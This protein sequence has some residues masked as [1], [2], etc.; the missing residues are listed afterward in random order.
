MAPPPKDWLVYVIDDHGY[1]RTM[2]RALLGQM[3]IKNVEEYEECRKAFYRLQQ[4]GVPV[5]HLIV[6]DW[7]MEDMDGYEFTDSIRKDPQVRA[8]NIPIVVL[9]G[10]R[11]SFMLEQLRDMGVKAILNKPVGL[12]QL[13]EAVMMAVAGAG[14][15]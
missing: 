11:D 4:Q 6:L 10:E 14:K 13:Q 2:V 5:P 15:R 8:K 1:M 12:Q 7:H 3:G 9:T